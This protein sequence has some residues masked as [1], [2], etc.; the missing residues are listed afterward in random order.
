MRYAIMGMCWNNTARWMPQNPS[1]SMRAGSA[2]YCSNNM[3]I[4]KCPCLEKERRKITLY[5]IVQKR[6]I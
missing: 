5:S 2:P 3:T 1:P 4:G 6:K